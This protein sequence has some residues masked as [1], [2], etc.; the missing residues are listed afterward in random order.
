MESKVADNNLRSYAD[1][2]GLQVYEKFLH[3]TYNQ[4]RSGYFCETLIIVRC[5]HSSRAAISRPLRLKPQHLICLI[6]WSSSSLNLPSLTGQN[7]VL[8]FLG[9]LKAIKIKLLHA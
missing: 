9:F 4:D 3:Y 1:D 7:V 6:R 2:K 5:N 8:P